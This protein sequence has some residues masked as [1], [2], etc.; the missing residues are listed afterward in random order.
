VAPTLLANRKE[1]G[2]NNNHTSSKKYIELN[3]TTGGGGLQTSQRNS[4]SNAHL[5]TANQYN[6][7]STKTKS[8]DKS[9][10]NYMLKLDNARTPTGG[11]I[12]SGLQST[13]GYGNSPGSFG[14]GTGMI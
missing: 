1:K 13:L 9:Q 4:G 2:Q 5:K 12:G 6:Y 7:T 14:M 8:H 3:T 11:V 10:T